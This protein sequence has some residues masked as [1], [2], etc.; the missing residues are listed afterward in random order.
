MHAQVR[1]QESSLT[2]LDRVPGKLANQRYDYGQ[3]AIDREQDL[4]AKGEI[5]MLSLASLAVLPVLTRAPGFGRIE[6]EHASVLYT[7]YA[8]TYKTNS[9]LQ[10]AV[11]ANSDAA[12]H[13]SS[14]PLSLT[15]LSSLSPLA[16]PPNHCCQRGMI[17]KIAMLQSML[18]LAVL[19]PCMLCLLY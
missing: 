1:L 18:I 10:R 2:L 12:T 11:G 17:L 9:L 3:G 6:K 4:L 7:A 5:G 16:L 8:S 14:A 19:L 15:P 13:L